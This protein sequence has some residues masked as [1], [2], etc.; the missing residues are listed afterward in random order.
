MD[1]TNAVATNQESPVLVLGA[2]GKTDRRVARR[3]ASHGVPTRIMPRAMA[4]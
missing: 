2:T 3:L 1:T 4:A